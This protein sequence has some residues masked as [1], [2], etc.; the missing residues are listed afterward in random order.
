MSYTPWPLSDEQNDIIE[1]CRTFAKDKIRPAGP[2]VDEADTE[3]PVELFREAA[4]VGITDFMIPEEYGGGGFTDVFTQC[5]V[6]EQLCFGDPGIGN[7]LC[8]NGFFAD[9]ILALGTEEQK[10]TWLRPLTGPE[11][12][13][14]A[15]ATTEPGSGSDSASITTRAEAV[16]GGYLLNGQKAWISNAGLAEGY[17]VFAKTDPAQRSRGVTA[18][19]LPRETEGMEFGAPMKKM[20]QRA[21]VCREIFFSDV[22]VPTHNRL[23]EEGRGFYGLMRTFDISRV[24]LGAAALGTARAA[25]EYARDYAR[26]R[27]QFGKAIIEH[28]SVA[29]RLADMAARIDAAWLQVLNAARMI[30]A[31]DG[32]EREKVTASAAMAKLGASETAMFCTWAGVQTLGG[33]GYSREHPV[34][35]WMRDAK[36][37]EIEEGTSDIMRLLISRN[38]P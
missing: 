4:R 9:P 37:E 38:L 15:L 26:E 35:Q 8:S 20:G 10:E 2:G 21:I 7:L 17:V 11:P 5:L 23:G 12:M 3:S 28:Q 1:L 27:T 6:Q 33:W 25:Y 19:L 31:G 29:F 18:F 36:L 16:D 22:F 32:V 30:D 14:T 24:V 34:E 13:F